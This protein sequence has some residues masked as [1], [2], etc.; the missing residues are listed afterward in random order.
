MS[1][2]SGGSGG[3]GPRSNGQGA[4][5]PAEAVHPADGSRDVAPGGQG[6]DE[7]LRRRLHDLYGG[8]ADE[9]IPDHLM[10]VVRQA[11]RSKKRQD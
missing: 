4:G 6:V 8:V 10:D 3:G 7:D 9:P 1:K 5:R 11:I 2:Q